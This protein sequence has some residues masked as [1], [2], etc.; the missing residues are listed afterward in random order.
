VDAQSS[1]HTA[2]TSLDD[3]ILTCILK[4]HM[5]SNGHSG[6]DMSSDWLKVLALWLMIGQVEPVTVID[7]QMGW[8]GCKR[9]PWPQVLRVG[10][11]CQMTC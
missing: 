5:S 1:K 3:K 9:K 6:S 4:F 8:D 7:Y 10:T 2:L 11:C